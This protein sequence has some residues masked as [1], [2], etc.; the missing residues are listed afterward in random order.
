L[1]KKMRRV[2]KSVQSANVLS[3]KKMVEKEG[4]IVNTHTSHTHTNTHTTPTPHHH[5]PVHPHS[6]CTCDYKRFLRCCALAA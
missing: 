6:Q 4:T 5:P 3:K 1:K 2:S